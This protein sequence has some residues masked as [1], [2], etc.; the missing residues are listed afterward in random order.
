MHAPKRTP[1]TSF[2]IEFSQP[3]Q[4]PGSLRPARPIFVCY[5]GIG[6]YPSVAMLFASMPP[7]P[8]RAGPRR[9][10]PTLP[11]ICI[12]LI[13][14]ALTPRNYPGDACC[15]NTL[16]DA[17]PNF[18]PP[19]QP[20]E[21]T[22]LATP[23]MTTPHTRPRCVIRTRRPCEAVNKLWPP[24]NTDKTPMEIKILIRVH[25]WPRLFSLHTFH[26]SSTPA[27]LLRAL[28]LA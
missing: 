28:Y 8:V 22:D 12:P 9:P 19:P 26:A 2:P 6:R 13:L 14:K 21:K 4:S 18:G 23:Q 15:Q 16:Q 11:G 27:S 7:L 1:F 20:T 5:T 17:S 25:P 3:F 24:R 10:E